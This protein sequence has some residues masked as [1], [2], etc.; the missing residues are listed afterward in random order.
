MLFNDKDV[1]VNIQDELK[2]EAISFDVTDEAKWL[3]FYNE[4]GSAGRRQFPAEEHKV[5][6]VQER[7]VEYP[8]VNPDDAT[9]IEESIK[10]DIR[11]IVDSTWGFD[12]QPR[13]MPIKLKNLLQDLEKFKKT[14][15][16]KPEISPELE[17]LQ[18]SYNI[19]GFPINCSYIDTDSIVSEVLDTGVHRN[20]QS[21]TSF[22][23]EVLV[24]PYIQGVFSVWVY[25]IALTPKNAR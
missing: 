6:P 11:N 24:T 15:A 13:W 4:T 17:K 16:P 3:S 2:P 20:A 14:G 22:G 9:S 25:F 21:A 12:S 5:Y 23:L 18:R 10:S 7:K 1:Y 8:L 19:A